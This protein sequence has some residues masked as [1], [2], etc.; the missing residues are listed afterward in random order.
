MLIGVNTAIY[1]PSGTY[2]GIG[3]AIPVDMVNQVVPQ[4]IANGTPHV[5]R[6]DLGVTVIEARQINRRLRN[7]LLVA[8][9]KP[10]SGAA[11][12]G[13]QP[14]MRGLDGGIILGDL[15]LAIDGQP[16]QTTA[17]LARIIGK[18]KPGDTVTLKIRRNGETEDVPVKL[19]EA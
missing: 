16:V 14:T 4:V 13:I 18:H 11:E 5:S 9:V 7:G 15:I 10:G 12:A 2:A 19:Q 1:S 3:F 6:A 17:D 8:A